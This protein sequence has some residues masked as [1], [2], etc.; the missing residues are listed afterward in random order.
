MSVRGCRRG[1]ALGG[2]MFTSACARV[3]ASTGTHVCEHTFKGKCTCVGVWGC[4]RVGVQGIRVHTGG[5]VGCTRVCNAA[6][7][8]SPRSPGVHPGG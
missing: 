4:T 6:A 3:R 8:C 5:C 2:E 7:L 1:N